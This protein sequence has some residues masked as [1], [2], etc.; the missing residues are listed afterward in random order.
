MSFFNDMQT[1]DHTTD[2]IPSFY[3]ILE[4]SL[5]SLDLNIF[6]LNKNIQKYCYFSFIS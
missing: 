2:F 4:K 1:N 3:E 6:Q 5:I